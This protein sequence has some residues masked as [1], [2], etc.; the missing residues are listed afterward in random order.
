MDKIW[1]PSYNNGEIWVPLTKWQNMGAPPPSKASTPP[2][3][4]S[5]WSLSLLVPANLVLY[6]YV[7]S[8]G[9]ASVGSYTTPPG[10]HMYY[11]MLYHVVIKLQTGSVC[12][13][14]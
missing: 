2:I 1:V 10:G 13:C 7:P 12:P 6:I 11:L 14:A 5:E 9:I 8:E 3:I 4:F